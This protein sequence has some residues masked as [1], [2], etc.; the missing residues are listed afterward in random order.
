MNKTTCT[1]QTLISR[2]SFM[3]KLRT[4]VMITFLFTATVCGAAPIEHYHVQRESKQTEQVVTV[5]AKSTISG[6]V[7]PV[8]IMAETQN[9]LMFKTMQA[10][11]SLVERQPQATALEPVMH[12]VT[13]GVGNIN[14]ERVSMDCD[15]E[16]MV[17][18]VA[19]R[20]PGDI[21]MS[22]SKPLD[23]LDDRLVM[24][25]V[26]HRRDLLVSDRASIEMLANYIRAIESRISEQA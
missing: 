2:E 13:D 6:D 11:D 7:V 3:R 23:T 12:F 24:F 15:T 10:Y 4:G 18:N 8:S 9:S 1:V 16:S 25:N 22:I 26:Y 20:M 17:L 19:Y 14:A 21:L 5:P